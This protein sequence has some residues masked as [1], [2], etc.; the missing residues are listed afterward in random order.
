MTKVAILKNWEHM[1]IDEQ[2]FLSQCPD[3]AGRSGEVQ[4]Q[5]GY[6]ETCDYIIVLN[7][8]LKNTS[9]QLPRERIWGLIQEPPNEIYKCMHSGQAAFGRVYNQA[10]DD[11][12]RHR[13]APPF[14]P[15]FVR[16][17]WRQLWDAAVPEKSGLVSC[18]TSRNTFFRGHVERLAFLDRAAAELGLEM[19]GRGIREIH[20][21]WD[22]HAPFRYSVVLENYRNP[23]YWTEKITDCFLSW[24]MPIYYGCERLSCYFPEESFLQIDIADSDSIEVIK[25]FIGTNAFEKNLDAIAEA[26][27]RV[28]EEHNFFAFI[29]R[30]IENDPESRQILPGKNKTLIRSVS[31]P[32]IEAWSRAYFRKAELRFKSAF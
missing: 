21:K 10:F 25:E 18:I 9:V 1:W 17:S 2:A 3:G 6:D 28:L 5:L 11:F 27:R 24:T 30:E 16:G 4:F 23:Y 22:A 19:F 29:R 31:L 12:P 20:Q 14:I 8:P 15:W 32:V 13:L 26:R 7:R